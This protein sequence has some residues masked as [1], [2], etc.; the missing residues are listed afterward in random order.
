MNPHLKPVG[1]KV[2]RE[3][4]FCLVCGAEDE[5][6]FQFV[7]CAIRDRFTAIFWGLAP[8]LFSFFMLHDP[9][10]IAKFLHERFV[11]RAMLPEVT[12]EVPRH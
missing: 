2:D 10:V 3:Q 6:H 9:R 7:C 4:R 1:Q 12:S 5:H 11:H 8:S